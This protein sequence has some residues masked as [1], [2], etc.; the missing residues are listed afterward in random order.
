M[1]YESSFEVAY[2]ALEVASRV[3]KYLFN[4]AY[5][6]WELAYIDVEPTF[7]MAKMVD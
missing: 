5:Y 2:R 1:S 4:C 7:F 6:A 3:N